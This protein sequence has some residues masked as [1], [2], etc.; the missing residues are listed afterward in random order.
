MGEWVDYLIEIF[1]LYISEHSFVFYSM[2][3]LV[4]DEKLFKK[5]YQKKHLL[6]IINAII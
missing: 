4:F 3:K 2:N 1:K 6:L 5:E